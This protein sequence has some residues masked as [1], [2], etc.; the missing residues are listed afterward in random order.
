MKF[1][2]NIGIVSYGACLPTQAI[3]ASEIEKTQGRDIGS[4]SKSLG[5]DQKT[6]P[7]I[8]ED[9]A[10]LATDAS[11][12]ALERLG[13]KQEIEALFVGSESHP[14]A[15]K[16]TGTI[17]KEAL[18]L[19]E[20]MS[21]AD[22]QFACKAGTQAL[23]ICASYIASGMAKQAVAIGADTAQ[24]APGDVLEFTASAGAVSFIL[25]KQN[26]L[27]KLIATGSVA[28]DTPD[29]W[30]RSGEAY[31]KHAGRFTGEPAYFYHVETATKNLLKEIKL[32]P[33][34]IDHCIF[35]T[36][37]AKF[38]QLVAKK[39]GFTK[40]QLANSL[41]VKKIGNTYAA[42]AM[43]AL[44]AV[45]DKAKTGEKILLTSY[46]SGAGA[47]SFLFEVAKELEVRRERWNNL[48]ASQIKKLKLI[49]YQEYR[50][51]VD[52]LSH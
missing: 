16:P 28:T 11:L 38:P 39:L 8:D 31:P 12:Q 19:S 50:E 14:Y 6:V 20:N 32:E 3:A 42:A 46:G 15:V 18:G 40:E 24:A 21:L 23:Q 30:R 37:N 22:L 35:H 52:L 45:L 4:V 47:D 13:V 26:I 44:A 36:P 7:G 34:D 5:V 27:A 43:L 1:K 2:K 48:L 17:V 51:A 9:T 33:K 29:F 25:G 10:T 49:N 41:I